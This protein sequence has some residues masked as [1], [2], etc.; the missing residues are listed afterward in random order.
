[1]A[2]STVIKEKREN[3]SILSGKL[4]AQVK[5]TQLEG[6]KVNDLLMMFV[7][8]S[9][10]EKEFNTFNGWQKIGYSVRKGSKAFLL[11]G[12]PVKSRK[13][14]KATEGEQE[15]DEFSFFP[16]AYVFSNEQ[17]IKISPD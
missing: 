15:P 17:V 7:Y 16:L 3:L 1:M 9:D 13:E 6:E 8:N 4:K 14:S 10:K 11:W 12:Q 2:Y 5:G